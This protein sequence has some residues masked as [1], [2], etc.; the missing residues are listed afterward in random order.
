MELS[1]LRNKFK[2]ENEENCDNEENYDYDSLKQDKIKKETTKSGEKEEVNAG[3]YLA[4]LNSLYAE[5][6]GLCAYTGRSIR[7]NSKKFKK[8]KKLQIQINVHFIL[9]I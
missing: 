6:G 1:I 7:P 8:T 3:A 5:Q 4:V 9:S 2:V